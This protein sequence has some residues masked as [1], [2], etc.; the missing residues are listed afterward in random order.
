MRFWL[1]VFVAVR[2]LKADTAVSRT[3]EN[4]APRRSL[5][6]SGLAKMLEIL[7]PAIRVLATVLLA[8]SLASAQGGTPAPRPEDET[9]VMQLLAG[10]GLHDIENESWNAYGQFTYISSWKPSF[11]APY[12]NL[13]GS[14]NS[15]LPTAERSFTGTATL[16]LGVRLWNGAEGYL[17]PELITEQP[18]SQLRGLGSAIQNFELQKGGATVPQIYKS[19]LFIKQTIGLGG[20]SNVVESGPLQLGTRYDSRR[21]VFAAGNFTILDFFD[22]NAFDVDPRKGFLGLGFMTY[23][24]YDF[25]S[26]ARGYSYGGIAEFHWD[27]WA[28]RVG[29]ITPPKD[30]NQLP[31][32]FRLFKYYGDQAEI[33]HR[34]SVHGQEGM[35]R[36]LAFRNRENM[37]R[38]SDAIAAFDADPSKNATTCTGFNYGSNNST[39]PDLCW[40]RKP[41]VKKGI[42]AF[43]EQYIGRD[44]GVFGR[45]MYADGETEVY[46][47]TSDDRSATIGVL[48]KGTS[49]SRSKDMAGIGENLGWISSIH[50]KYLGMGGI[51]GF[52]GD[53]AITAASERSVDLFYSAN[54]RKIYW[55][56][57]DYQHIT[58]PGFNA[59]RGPVNVFTVRIHG[60]F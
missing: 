35:V 40:A 17:V 42:G 10:K 2:N 49:W 51:D 32:D 12:T 6:Q 1:A 11:D 48:A 26:D 59:A 4:G 29:R 13:N 53:G 15:L 39:A 47:Y 20:K 9:S 23:G 34:H 60:E 45:G 28:V 41:N 56:T 25:A 8:S 54:F 19:R 30:P 16:Y 43:A 14:I 18:L 44:I 27:D 36:V 52:V 5:G 22:T 24:A 33:V 21:L 46:A 3:H 55:L 58:N 31:V 7:R 50:A 37:G 57:G 38:F